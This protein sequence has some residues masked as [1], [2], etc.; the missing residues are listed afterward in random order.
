[1]AAHPA[2]STISDLV[3]IFIRGSKCKTIA[4]GTPEAGETSRVDS[5]E[6]LMGGV[7]TAV[8]VAD[9]IVLMLQHGH[10]GA[11]GFSDVKR[12]AITAEHF[13]GRPFGQDREGRR[14]V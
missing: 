2:A 13:D 1:M 11:S 5:G 12:S 9:R 6:K 3:M 14:C 7:R 8:L 10:T 4:A